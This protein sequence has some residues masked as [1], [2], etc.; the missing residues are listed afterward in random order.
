M[1][2]NNLQ[3]EALTPNNREI[4]LKCLKSNV[5]T[6]V[7]SHGSAWSPILQAVTPN[8]N[9]ETDNVG[10]TPAL[11]KS[12]GIQ[13]DA[14]DANVSWRSCMATPTSEASS[15]NNATVYHTPDH[16]EDK[17]KVSK[18]FENVELEI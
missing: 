7:N 11:L 9:V 4:Q 10:R 1:R 18:S 16:V 17:A 8:L 15:P 12:L 6:P 2:R 5:S 13:E 3:L 14:E